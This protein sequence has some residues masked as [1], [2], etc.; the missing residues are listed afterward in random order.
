MYIETSI[1]EIALKEKTSF[2]NKIKIFTKRK[3]RKGVIYKEKAET[4]YRNPKEHLK[5]YFR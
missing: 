2:L 4:N 3:I 1:I 5:Q